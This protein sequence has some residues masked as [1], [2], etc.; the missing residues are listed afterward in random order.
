MDAAAAGDVATMRISRTG[1][2]SLKSF[3]R[4]SGFFQDSWIF[5]GILSGFLN[6]L[7]DSF[8]IFGYFKGFHGILSGFLN[9]LRNCKGFQGIL[10]GFLDISKDSKGFYGISWDSFRILSDFLDI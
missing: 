3:N 5:Y 9:I 8:R 10:S 1:F 4:F 2:E 6:I 7:W